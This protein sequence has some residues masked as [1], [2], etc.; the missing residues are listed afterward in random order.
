MT[1]LVDHIESL[2]TRPI[3]IF[4]VE[5]SRRLDGRV[6]VQPF[7]EGVSQRCEQSVKRIQ[8]TPS[9]LISLMFERQMLWRRG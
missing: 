4:P 6:G 7:L 1:D 2:C 9:L 5:S 3:K 8:V